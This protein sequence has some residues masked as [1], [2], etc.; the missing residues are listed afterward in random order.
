MGQEIRF[1]LLEELI[2]LLRAYA[3]VLVGAIK[4]MDNE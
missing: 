4:R 3:P 1:V 2:D